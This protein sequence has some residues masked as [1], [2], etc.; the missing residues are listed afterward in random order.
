MIED[1]LELA[2]IITDYLK[3]FDIEVTNIDSPYTGLSMISVNKDF[4]LLIL[5]LTLPEIDGLELIPK[6]REKSDIPIIIS[7]A[8]DD[9]LDKVM[10]L[11]RGADDYLPKPY[12]PREL[13]AR[14][15]TILKRM[16]SNSSKSKDD[17][18]PISIFEVR[19]NDMQI[20]FKGEAL[21]LTLAEYDILKLLIQRNH[22]VV[23]R[24][25]FIYASDNIEDDSSLKNIDV[26]ISR[27]R[28]KLSR[29]DD[30]KTYIKSVRG[31]GYQ[32]I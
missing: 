28:T 13:Q 22:G 26:I 2:Q 8:R 14:I 1:D 12:N 16:D 25:D 29:I 6:I 3:S 19:E 10:G 32:L 9:I 11:E 17:N 15:K 7:S 27:I 24:E 5:D 31:I 20:Y 4:E 30:S 21:T 18:T 23:A